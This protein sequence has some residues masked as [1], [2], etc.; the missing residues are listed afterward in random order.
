MSSKHLEWRTD[1]SCR[2]EDTSI[3]F[4][5]DPA[6]AGR[7]LAMC[8]GCPV[9][10]SCLEF[11]LNSRQGDGIWGGLNEMERRRERRRRRQTTAA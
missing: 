7:A 4:S 3:F 1:A 5:D 11:A 6:E 10:Q 9:R 2:D 8:A